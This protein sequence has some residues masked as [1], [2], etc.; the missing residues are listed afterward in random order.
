M[1]AGGAKGKPVLRKQA[2]AGKQ[3]EV[4]GLQR[5]EQREDIHTRCR[6]PKDR[7]DVSGLCCCTSDRDKWQ[8]LQTL[9][10]SHIG[11]AALCII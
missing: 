1:C 3:D 5:S 8:R 4:Q 7:Q 2:R 11:P 6:R 10:S 9:V